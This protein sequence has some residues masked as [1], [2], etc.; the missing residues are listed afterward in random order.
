MPANA[1][2]R[3]LLPVLA[4]AT[5]GFLGGYAYSQNE[6]GGLWGEMLGE[7]TR[8]DPLDEV[9]QMGVEALR[10]HVGVLQAYVVV[11]RGIS[12]DASPIELRQEFYE[13]LETARSA[14]ASVA[15]QFSELT[16]PEEGGPPPLTAEELETLAALG[17]GSTSDR[18]ELAGT[19]VDL[20]V[21]AAERLGRIVANQDAPAETVN[22]DELGRVYAT[23]STTSALVTVYFGLPGLRSSDA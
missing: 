12:P 22:P 10:G 14:F 11:L 1:M 9:S 17:F 4:A 15:E 8:A 21:S 18:Q 7:A 2:N 16:D 6:G 3:R 23:A 5:L 19:I 20:S 13:E